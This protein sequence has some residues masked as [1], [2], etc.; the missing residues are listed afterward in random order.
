M[1]KS[2]NPPSSHNEA[3]PAG[4]IREVFLLYAANVKLLLVPTVDDRTLDQ[5]L[6][7]RDKVYRVIESE[8]FLGDLTDAFG[9]MA[10]PTISTD[11]PEHRAIAEALLEELKAV[12]RAVEVSQAVVT[13]VP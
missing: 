12:S 4:E 3:N 1:A 9:K 11:H 7:F 6:P 10:R 2:P 13:G 5:F 8:T